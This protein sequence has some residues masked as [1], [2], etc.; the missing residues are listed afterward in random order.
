MV[1]VFMD[2][3]YFSV[4]S[5]RISAVCCL[6]ATY[7]SIGMFARAAKVAIVPYSPIGICKV[8]FMR[9]VTCCR[10]IIKNYSVCKA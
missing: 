1:F 8:I 2:C 4:F 5:E 9:S 7:L 3:Y 10:Y 6:V